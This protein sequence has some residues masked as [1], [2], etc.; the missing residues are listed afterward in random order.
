MIDTKTRTA[1]NKVNW[2]NKVL[3]ILT[4]RVLLYTKKKTIITRHTISK[5]IARTTTN[6]A[7]K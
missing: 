4:T 3:A 7:P 2:M 5:M 6:T 1:P